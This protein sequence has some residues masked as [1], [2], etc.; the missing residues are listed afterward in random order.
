MCEVVGLHDLDQSNPYVVE[1][2]VDFMNKAI[3]AGVA[4]FRYTY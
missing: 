1:K 2:I 3:N 4:G